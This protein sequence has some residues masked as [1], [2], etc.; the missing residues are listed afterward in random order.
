MNKPSGFTHHTIFKHPEHCINQ[1]ATRTL[2]N[3]DLLAVFNEQRFPFHHDT[4]QTLMARSRD[5]GKTWGE[6]SI[7]LPWSATEGNWVCWFWDAAAGT[8]IVNRPPSGLL[9]GGIKP[10]Q[11]PGAAQPITKEWGAWT[12]TYK[13][14]EWL[15]TYVVKSKDG[16]KSWT[17][18]IPVN[19]LPMKYG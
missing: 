19:V 18:P 4:G 12:W 5:G 17:Q 16:G 10:E 2:K 9:N 15:G 3:G 8:L 11:P 13:L 14:Q 6:P 7:V 1:I